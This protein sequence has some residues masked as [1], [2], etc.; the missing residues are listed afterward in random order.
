[1]AQKRMRKKPKNWVLEYLEKPV[2]IETLM[3]KVKKAYKSKFESTMMAATFAEAGEFDTAKEIRDSDKE[4]DIL[5][6]DKKK[7]K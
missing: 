1:M 5:N 6:K 4:Q 2:E 3:K 7:S